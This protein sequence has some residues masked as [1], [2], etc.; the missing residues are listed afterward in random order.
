MAATCRAGSISATPRSAAI[1]PS[2]TPSTG[3][4]K[5][6]AIDLKNEA[7]FAGFAR[8]VVKADVMIQNFRPG[9]IERLGFDYEAVRKHQPTARLPRSAPA[10][11]K[12]VHGSSGPA[13][14]CWRNHAFRRD[15]AEWR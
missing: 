3:P 4:R 14:I 9:V 2:S 13:R 7:D 8:A 12:T 6:F 10:M 11:A 15:V 5:A 1:P